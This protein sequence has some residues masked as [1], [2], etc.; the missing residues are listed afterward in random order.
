MTTMEPPEEPEADGDEGLNAI[1]NQM[2]EGLDLD[3]VQIEAT[4]VS[5]LTDLE[6]IRKFKKTKDELN[7]REELLTP[8]TDTGK[9]LQ[10]QYHAY[11]IEMRKRGLR[12]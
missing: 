7:R 1:F 12:R 5:T 4:V 2:T 10:T 11:L 6:L 9:D 8:K 3:P